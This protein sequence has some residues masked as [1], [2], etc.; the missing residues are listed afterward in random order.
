MASKRPPRLTEAFIRS[1]KEPCKRGDGHGSH[2]LTIVVRT[3]AGGGLRFIWRQIFTINGKKRS[4][5]LG[6]HPLITL[7][8]AR[9]KAFEN[10]RSIAL[11]E[12]IL[13]PPPPPPPTPSLG[14]AFDVLKAIKAAS[15]KRERTAKDTTRMWN[16]SKRHCK[17]ILAKSLSD[18]TKD[19]VN[20]IL[21]P[22]WIPKRA[23]GSRVQNHLSQI[24]I[25]AIDHEYR[26]TN[27]A[28]R[29][30]VTLSLG[31]QPPPENYPAADYTE[32]DEFLAT[33]RDSDYW[34]AA[35]YCLLFIA[36]TEDRGGEAREA[37][38]S[39]VDWK[40]EIL[41]IPAE[42]MKSGRKH[43]VPLSPP[44]MDILRLAWS[45]P[46][47]SKGIIF[48]PERGGTFLNSHML[49]QIPRELGLPF[50]PHG[51][52][53]T[54]G[55]WAAEHENSEYK[56]LAKISLAH[57]VDKDSDKPYFRTPV[58]EKRRAMLHDYAQFLTQKHGSII[59]PKDQD[60][61]ATDLADIERAL[62]RLFP[63]KT[64]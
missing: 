62:G 28:N 4:T 43:I 53:A 32:L 61:D 33:I 9:D 23:A 6:S 52:R 34:W 16:D 59:S 55:D 35:K 29:R 56:A 26:T 38:W 10:A 17:P 7:K 2:G 58:I 49:S 30:S 3:R 31:K 21:R 54:F 51:L 64:A 25:W 46:H 47:H 19:D 48:P 20:D 60:P 18:I 63:G 50:V 5:G 27:P 42:R 15:A 14:E 40:K 8:M 1:I 36:F 11:G 13:T 24:L 41:T 12:D 22:I 44:A 37:I 39:D 45:K 57:T